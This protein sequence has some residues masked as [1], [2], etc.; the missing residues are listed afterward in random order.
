MDLAKL[1]A[2]LIDG[3]L[4]F[5]SGRTLSKYDRLEGQPTYIEVDRL[6]YDPS[7]MSP[8]TKAAELG[9]HDPEM[10]ASFLEY[11]RKRHVNMAGFIENSCFFSCWHMNDGESDAMW[12]IYARNA[13]GVAIR[14]T[15]ARLKK[16][17]GRD[18]RKIFL[19][20]IK[21]IDFNVNSDSLDIFVRRFMRKNK[22]F[23]HEQE[24]RAVLHDP[25]KL[26]NAGERVSVDPQI[27]IERIVISPTEEEWFSTLVK[28]VVERI[29]C[30]F[31]V[32]PSDATRVPPM[33]LLR[34]Q[35]L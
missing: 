28:A 19:G 21:Y 12:K 26:N 20:R 13:G 6:S 35:T 1:L 4:F 16:S 32:V 15:V 11:E 10:L 31:D 17:F 14:S 27:L 7:L 33:T 22:A 5:P 29:G 18:I 8:S 23:S 3:A 9:I 24:L 25:E 34:S 30:A 2:I